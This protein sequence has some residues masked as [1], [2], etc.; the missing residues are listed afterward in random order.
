MTVSKE[1][2]VVSKSSDLEI[3]CLAKGFPTPD[4]TWFRNGMKVKD[5]IQTKGRATMKLN[6]VSSSDAGLYICQATNVINDEE[7][8][9]EGYSVV[10]GIP[11]VNQINEAY[12]LLIIDDSAM[13]SM[14][15][16]LRQ[17]YI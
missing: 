5:Q 10:E 11:V 1:A 16:N 3:Y 8:K 9:M 7:Y 12:E 6:R 15:S 14:P 2:P 13:A 4:V 17:E